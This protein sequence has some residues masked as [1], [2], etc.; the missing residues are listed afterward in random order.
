MWVSA[1][2]GEQAFTGATAGGEVAPIADLQVFLLESET[3]INASL[4]DISLSEA[5]ILLRFQ[6]GI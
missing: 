5:Q 3:A 2:G 1:V 4:V 6:P